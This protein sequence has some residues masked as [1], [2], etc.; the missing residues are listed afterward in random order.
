M[1]QLK[2]ILKQA[3]KYRFW[4]AVGISALLPLIAYFVGVGA[5]QAEAAKKDGEIRSAEK[6]VKQYSGGN[7]VNG[8][9]K[10]IVV[11]KT[12]ELTKDVNA[13]W[14]KLYARQAPLLKWPD[15]VHER[16]SAWGR[17]WPENVDASA[18][19]IAI[20]DYINAY[21]PF[22]TE[23]YKS[24]RPFD[25]VEGTGVV[26]APPEDALLR[27]AK[28]AIET[29]PAL[30]KV[31]AA[32]ERLWIQRTL[33]DVVNK[34]NKDAKT[35]DDAIV[36]QVNG[37]EVGSALAQ[38]QRS[39]AKGDTLEDA[40]EI[41]D[42]SKPEESTESADSSSP[43]AMMMGPMAGMSR[44]MGGGMGANVAPETVSYIKTE[45]TQFKIMPVRLEVL[46]DQDHIQDLLVA[47]ENSPM[48]IQVMDFEMSKPS[49]RVVKPE[50]GQAIGFGMGGMMMGNMENMMMMMSGMSR[51]AGFGGNMSR[52]GAGMESM[53][54]PMMGPMGAYGMGGSN[55]ARKK[56][57]DARTKNRLQEAKERE[58]AATKVV[59]TAVVDPYPNIIEVKVTGQARFFNPPPA[60]EAE[61]P[62]QSENAPAEADA[63]KKDEA[64][65]DAKKEE[66]EAEKK[67]EDAK[68]A[69]T[70]DAEKKDDNAKKEDAA[71]AEPEK[72]DEAAKAEPEK[73]EAAKAEAPKGE[74]EKKDETPKKDET[75]K[76]GAADATPKK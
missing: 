52:M 20:I 57:V 4:I 67:D 40:P 55:E 6:D 15:R 38:D 26:S 19:Q 72:K 36:K 44:M 59:Q 1:D 70:P 25:P 76:D 5:V 30:G 34:V 54:S 2:E 32:Q 11:T 68:K 41:D 8:Q 69:E 48:T 23:V 71:K 63:A 64:P 58:E 31:W 9:Y 66:G 37:L 47:L 14:K 75:A 74:G 73:E 16:F 56:G 49:T 7:I 61:A 33:L 27:P 43:M 51:R 62:S 50:K 13:S 53:M 46:I 12:E 24:F 21:Q 3:I 29:P 22:V 42:P 35:W 60:E 10:P 45:S 18:V 17:K 39:I 28:F 65:A